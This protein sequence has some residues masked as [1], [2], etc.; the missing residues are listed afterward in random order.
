MRIVFMGTPEFA[1]PALERLLADRY[2]I[3]AVYTQPDQTA[4]RGRTPSVPPVKTA[5]LRWGV[6]VR[7]PVGLRSA[8]ERASLAELKPDVAVVAAFGQIL[9]QAVLEIPRHGF[10]NIH[11]SLLP[12]YR[13]VAP[14]P[15]AILNG[16]EF[17][18]VTIMQLDRGVDTGPVLVEGQVP[19]A[20]HDTAASLM[21]KLA[22]V[23][24]ALLLEALPRWVG[25]SLAARAQDETKAT[26][27]RMIQKEA[28][29][30]DWSQPA[31]KIWRQV[32]AYYPW[33]GSWT[34]WQGKQIKVLEAVPLAG[35]G[36]STGRVVPLAGEAAFGVETG[37]GILGVVRVQ[38]EG[39]RAMTAGEF[40]RGQRGIIGAVLPG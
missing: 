39:K 20:E 3:V 15:A 38:M 22:R 10:L 29:E 8:A 21:D 7:Q 34:R 35:G 30:I 4:G 6:P 1:V 36:G 18:G 13:G 28:G 40:L 16:D 27:T 2:E 26:C 12:A 19:V 14:V 17:T 32:R 37:R 31:V 25:G 5:A 11:P 24:A 9:T 33:P 23:G